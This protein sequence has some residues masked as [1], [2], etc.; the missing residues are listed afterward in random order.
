MKKLKIWIAFGRWSRAAGPRYVRT[1]I[2]WRGRWT[3]FV[4]VKRRSPGPVGKVTEPSAPMG[5]KGREA[6]R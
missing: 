1:R 3:P 2:Y 4:R 6:K 5:A